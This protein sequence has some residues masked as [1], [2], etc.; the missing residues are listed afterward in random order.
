M[1]IYFGTDGLRGIYGEE[2]TPSIAFKCGNSL[3]RFCKNKKVI[4]GK[5][6]RVT[7]DILTFSVANGLMQNGIDVIDV[8][9]VPTPAIA[10]LT[11]C[12]ECD[13]GIVISASHNPPMYN[14]IKI[15][16]SEGYKISESIEN[17]IERKF[18]S[19][20]S[21]PFYNIGR[22]KYRPNLIQKYI[23]NIVS[24][25]G[26]L[27]GLKIVIDCGN[28][29]SSKIAKE[30]FK[31]LNASVI[32]MNYKTDGI[33]I[34]DDC[35]ALY[36]QSMAQMVRQEKADLGVA[37]DGDADRIYAC[38]ENGN[39]VDGDDI[40]YVLA[41]YFKDKNGY[42]VGTS[43][44]NKGFE[45]A[46]NKK[47][48]NLL[49][50]DVGDKYVIEIMKN[51]NILL[52]GEPSGHIIVKSYSTTGDGI[53]TGLLLS[54]IIKK[55][56][57]PLSK[58]IDYKKFPQVNINV[59]TIDKYR[60][61]NSEKLSSAILELQQEFKNKGRVLV[62]ASGTENKVRIMCEHINKT[63]AL[64]ASQSL[65]NIIKDLNSQQKN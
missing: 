42:V 44:S 14:G 60:I 27:K 8:G 39:L 59:T 1:G 25:I 33:S 34:N 57:K 13:Y 48:I 63:T 58:L 2:I 35:G 65:E 61:L 22:Y 36:P 16:D 62:R 50:A 46:L 49:R 52:G 55:S 11:K 40:L 10:Y 38:D 15:F 56:C 31:N 18:M 4:I 45:N 21:E 29:A 12:M 17:S 64:R 51:K 32:M 6:P 53:L 30:I 3:S 26:D 19:P 20:C 43:L 24:N 7:G 47:G 54:N 41:R 9:L 37:F 28:G 5:D 23:K